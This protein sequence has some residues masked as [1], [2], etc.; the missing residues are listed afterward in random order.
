MASEAT[1]NSDTAGQFSGLH[2]Y[3][4]ICILAHQS[5]V[6]D[7]GNAVKICSFVVNIKVERDGASCCLTC[8][9]HCISMC[10][11]ECDR[12][13]TVG[14]LYFKSRL[15]NLPKI[16]RFNAFDSIDYCLFIATVTVS[17]VTVSDNQTTVVGSFQINQSLNE[18]P[19]GRRSCSFCFN[20][21]LRL[22]YLTVRRT[23]RW[24]IQPDIPT[25]SRYA[26]SSCLDLLRAL[27]RNFCAF[28]LI[29][30]CKSFDSID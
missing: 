19:N 7:C 22:R 21:A 25:C 15:I 11:D 27:L 4:I 16:K 17:R 2:R 9:D 5:D 20:H 18:L 29:K 8:N 23:C 14:L 6:P 28:L 13:S 12:I 3:R 30:Q 24:I 10:K 26:V 1:E